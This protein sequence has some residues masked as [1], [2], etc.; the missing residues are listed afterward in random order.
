MFDFVRSHNRVLQVMLGI[1]IIPVFG[2]VGL[3]SYLQPNESAV[4]VASVTQHLGAPIGSFYHRFASRDVLLA[5]L[6]L[7]TVLAF[8]EGFVAAIEISDG[9]AEFDDTRTGGDRREVA[10]RPAIHVMI[11]R[12]PVGPDTFS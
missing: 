5:E 9:L 3:S 2:F 1:V 12:H 4:T 7:T 8:Q 10:P 6:W 11:V